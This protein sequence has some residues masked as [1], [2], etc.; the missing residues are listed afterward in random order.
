[1]SSFIT[2]PI[3]ISGEYSSDFLGSLLHPDSDYMHN[4][5]AIFEEMDRTININKNGMD[6]EVEI[7]DLDLSFLDEMD[8]SYGKEI[9]ISGLKRTKTDWIQSDTG[10]DIDLSAHIK[11]KKDSVMHETDDGLQMQMAA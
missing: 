7:Q 5:R 1:M 6:I 4:Q 8:C 2:E 11:R 3:I 9:L 10:F